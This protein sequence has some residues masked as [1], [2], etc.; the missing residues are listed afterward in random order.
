MSYCAPIVNIG[1]A[2]TA[3]PLK[4]R[5]HTLVAEILQRVSALAKVLCCKLLPAQR[6]NN[7]ACQQINQIFLA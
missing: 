2:S 3:W 4:K 1:C 5:I 6:A 7:N